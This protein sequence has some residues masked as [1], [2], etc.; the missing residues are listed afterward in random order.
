[1]MKKALLLGTLVLAVACPAWAFGGLHGMGGHW[2]NSGLALQLDLTA[3]QKAQLESMQE[4]FAAE[5]GPLRD[6]LFGKKAELRQLWNEASP[7]EAKI[8]T[9]QQEIQELRNNLQ[10][11]GT[12]FEL[13][14]RQV[15]TPEQREKLST[16]QSHHGK[17]QHDRFMDANYVE[18]A[19]E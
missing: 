16:V 5:T 1:M 3:D 4:A 9:R 18:S 19:G 7:D 17:W 6:E 10:E 8:L 15:L 14:C 2:M 13:Q 12:H 11:R